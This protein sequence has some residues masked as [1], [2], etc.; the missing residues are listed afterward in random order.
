MPGYG[1]LLIHSLT[2]SALDQTIGILAPSLGSTFTIAASTLGACGFALPFYVFRT[3]VVS[4]D[5]VPIVSFLTAILARFS[6]D[7]DSSPHFT[8]CHSFPRFFPP[9]LRPNHRSVTEPL[10]LYA[11]TFHFG[12]P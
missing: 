11:A 4:G 3:V 9:V 7:T 8:R 2:S 6:C 5:R 10:V 12:V 1:A